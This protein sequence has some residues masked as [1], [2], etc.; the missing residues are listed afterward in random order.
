MTTN[1]EYRMELMK[2]RQERD[3]YIKNAGNKLTVIKKRLRDLRSGA[4]FPKVR[5]YE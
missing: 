1:A 5:K 4:M 3:E 2:L